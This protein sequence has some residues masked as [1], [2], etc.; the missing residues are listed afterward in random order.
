MGQGYTQF[1]DGNR[2]RMKLEDLR[3]PDKRAFLQ[4]I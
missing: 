1:P 2:Y 4:T 3:D